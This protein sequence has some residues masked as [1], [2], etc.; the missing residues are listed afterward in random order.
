MAVTGKQ[1]DEQGREIA[2]DT[3]KYQS[4][5]LVFALF[6]GVFGFDRFYLGHRSIGM[7]KLFTFGGFG[8]F[9][10]IDLILIF[11]N[12]IKD[13]QGNALVQE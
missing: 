6:L 2:A 4:V 1:K 8:L 11:L 10:A 3:V 7:L 13:A 12:S 5:A 9:S